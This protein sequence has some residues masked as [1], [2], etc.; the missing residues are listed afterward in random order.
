LIRKGLIRRSAT[1][2]G[3]NWL[4]DFEPIFIAPA[5]SPKGEAGGGEGEVK[6]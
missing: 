6:V 2:S 3:A 5:A 4:D 1:Y